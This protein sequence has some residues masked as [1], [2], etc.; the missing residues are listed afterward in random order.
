ML[1]FAEVKC[2]VTGRMPKGAR[3]TEDQHV[4]GPDAHLAIDTEP[5]VTRLIT[6][7]SWSDLQAAHTAE[8]NRTRA[9]DFN[10]RRKRK[11][12]LCI[13]VRRFSH[14]FLQASA[15]LL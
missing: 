6:D 14:S 2:A 7:F 8:G 15:N 3:S 11:T 1:R 5:K 9:F 13:A 12:A 10:E 4:G